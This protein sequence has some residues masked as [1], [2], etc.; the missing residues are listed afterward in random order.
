MKR[1]ATVFLFLFLISIATAA[2]TLTFQNEE[3]QPGETILATITTVG[4]F[5]KQIEPS[6]I[7]FYEGRK[8]VSFES[9]IKFYEGT[10]YLYVYTTRE[11][12]FSI[13][14]SGILYKEANTLQA[15]TITK[16]F[17]ITEEI[18]TDE[19]TNQTSTQI[20]QIKP[21]FVFTTGTPSIKLINKGTV[22]LNI[23]YGEL[24]ISLQPSETYDVITIPEQ[25]FSYINIST[26]KEFSIPIIY[27]TANATFISPSV[28]L[29]LRQSPELLLAELITNTESQETIELFNFGN[30]TLTNIQITSDFTFIETEEIEN[31]SARE[32]KNLTITFDPKIP[33]HFQGNINITYTQNAEQNTLSIP[34]SL[35]ILPEG[36]TTEDFE[37]VNETCTELSGTV[38][39]SG[40]ICTGEATFTKNQ[41]YCCLGTCES[42]E[43]ESEGGGFGWLI[44]IVIIAAL[45]FGG[46][47][48]YKKQKK[49]IPKKPSEQ[50]KESSEK[51]TERLKG[52]LESKRVKGSITKY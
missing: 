31:I 41:E 1:S 10:H 51:Y 2:P 45:G 23:K 47:Y 44:G 7:K 37:R 36:S 30:E 8:Q 43:Q 52:T 9:D 50:I 24:E 3:I 21:G 49:V 16:Q 39:E 27:P 20:L 13:E 35:F 26:Y 29:D 5:E 34:L 18:I 25:V 48:F 32:V 33:G 28:Q 22:E 14:I 6:D 17:N 11:G 4:N 19:E 12:N 46:Y 40:F 15:T 38:C 42:T